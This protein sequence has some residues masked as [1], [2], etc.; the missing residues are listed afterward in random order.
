MPRDSMRFA[1]L[2]HPFDE[3]YE[4]YKLTIDRLGYNSRK[5]IPPSAKIVT[6]VITQRYGEGSIFFKGFIEGLKHKG[7]SPRIR[8]STPSP[9]P[10]K[11][12]STGFKPKVTAETL[13]TIVDL[14]WGKTKS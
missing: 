5:P 10:K 8:P 3:T 6:E 11:E 7:F 1:I 14:I 2:Y 13:S 9:R 12:I 4:L